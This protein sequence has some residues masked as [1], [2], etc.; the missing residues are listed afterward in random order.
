MLPCASCDVAFVLSVKLFTTVFLGRD[1][2]YPNSEEK[3]NLYVCLLTV[4]V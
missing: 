4:G 1:R 2:T 3:I